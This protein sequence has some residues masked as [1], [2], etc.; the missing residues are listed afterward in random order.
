MTKTSSQAAAF[1]VALCLTASPSAQTT[2]GN[3]KN[4]AIASPEALRLVEVWLD[5]VQAYNKIAALS[6]AIVQGGKVVWSKGY[7]T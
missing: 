7:G 2:S 5:S 3:N 1:L 6:T 4:D